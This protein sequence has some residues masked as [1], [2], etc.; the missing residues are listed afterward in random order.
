MYNL[1]I[2]QLGDFE[3]SV[4]NLVYDIINMMQPQHD[5]VRNHEMHL[6]SY[7]LSPSVLV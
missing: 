1:A 4:L 6:I 7:F 2:N 5:I 3:I